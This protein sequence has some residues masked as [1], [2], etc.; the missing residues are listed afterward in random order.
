MQSIHAD[1]K[2][3]WLFVKCVF[4]KHHVADSFTAFSSPKLCSVV[5]EFRE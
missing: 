4:G 1:E 3:L 2:S 5:R